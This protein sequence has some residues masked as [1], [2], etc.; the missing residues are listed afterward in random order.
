MNLNRLIIHEIIKRENQERKAT[1]DLSDELAMKDPQAVKFVSELN[2]RYRSLRHSNGRFLEEAA[3]S[4]PDQFERYCREFKDRDFIEF[5]KQ[6][7]S[8]LSE[9]IAANGPAK[10]GYIVFADYIDVQHFVGIFLIRNKAGNVLQKSKSA[11][12]YVIN[13][14]LHIDFEHLAMACRI[15]KEAHASGT[16]SYLTFINRRNV[17]SNFFTSWICADEL[18]NNAED[19]RSLLKILK[20]IDPPVGENGQAI[21][22]VDFINAVYKFIRDTPKGDHTDLKQ[23]SAWFYDDENKL[24]SFAQDE[25]ISLNHQFKP[26]NSIL[27]QFVNIKAKADGIDLVFPQQFLDEKKVEI[28][29]ED[30]KIVIKSFALIEKIKAEM[31][32]SNG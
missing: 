8:E 28:F 29:I 18:I 27:R 23:I 31:I 13:E 26:D 22:Q 32:N 12:T 14:T 4:F 21:S 16:D 7:A 2:D 15:N 25:Q 6:T 30:G 24:S 3:G 5:T 1:V 19:T 17:D 9:I 20:Q 11:S 10:G